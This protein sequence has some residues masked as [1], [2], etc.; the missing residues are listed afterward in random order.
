MAEAK[1]NPHALYCDDPSL[2]VQSLKDECDINKIIARYQKSGDLTHVNERVARY[3]DF[4]NVPSYQEALD[5]VSRAENMFMEMSPEV[6]ERFANDPGK[7]VEFLQ[8]EKNYDEAVKLG[9]V[10]PKK[11]EAPASSAPAEQPAVVPPVAVSEPP[12]VG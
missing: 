2:T 4:S 5:L 7:M 8:D 12:K 6:R 11:K 10:L 9:L 3:G 1:R